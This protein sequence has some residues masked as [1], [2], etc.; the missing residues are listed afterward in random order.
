M[1]EVLGHKGSFQLFV[2]SII[3]C[4]RQQRRARRFRPQGLVTRDARPNLRPK[5]APQL[6]RDKGFH[7]RRVAQGLPIFVIDAG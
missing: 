5:A 6:F 7:P 1:K 4:S 3:A 2:L